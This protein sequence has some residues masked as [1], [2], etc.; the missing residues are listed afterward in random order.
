ME[1]HFR[2]FPLDLFHGGGEHYQETNDDDSG[3][4]VANLRSLA[5]SN[6]VIRSLSALRIPPDYMITILPLS[7]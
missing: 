1:V 2:P 3:F 6:F 7:E 5:K 4:P